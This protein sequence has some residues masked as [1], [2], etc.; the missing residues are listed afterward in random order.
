M[1]APRKI[2]LTC[3]LKSMIPDANPVHPPLVE[4]GPGWNIFRTFFFIKKNH[5]FR[6]YLVTVSSCLVRLS[7]DR[8]VPHR[9]TIGPPR[10]IAIDMIATDGQ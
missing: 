10:L 2:L 1:L 4:P 3:G 7:P 6:T 9:P 5:I 8:N